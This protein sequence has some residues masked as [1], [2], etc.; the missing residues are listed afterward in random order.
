VTK[1]NGMSVLIADD[2]PQVRS[3]LRALLRVKFG[4]ESIAEA[5]DLEQ[6][7]EKVGL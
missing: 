5:S 3:A 7:L 2:R 6:A 1:K 4:A